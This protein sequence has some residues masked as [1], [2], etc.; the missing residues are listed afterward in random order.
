MRA[1]HT[2]ALVLAVGLCVAPAASA[3]CPA[4]T[5]APP[6]SAAAARAL[7]IGITVHDASDLGIS[8]FSGLKP[9]SGARLM[10]HAYLSY[11]ASNEQ[12]VLDEVRAYAAAGDAVLLTIRAQLANDA[13]TPRSY[14]AFVTE[15]LA[16][17]GRQLTAV[18]ITNEPNL[19]APPS[20]SDGMTPDVVEDLVTGVVTAQRYIRAHELAIKVGFN[21]VF[22]SHAP[23][24][25]RFWSELK[26]AATPEFLGDVDFLGL[27]TYPNLLSLPTPV[28][29]SIN[30]AELD[31]LQTARCY[32][33]YLGLAGSVPIEITEVGYPV[34]NASYYAAQADYWAR[35]LDVIH[36]YRAS[37]NID[38]VY[39]FMFRTVASASTALDF[40]IV[41]ADGSP[42]PAYHLIRARIATYDPAAPPTARVAPGRHRHRRHRRRR[43]RGHANK[44]HHR[45]SR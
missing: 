20:T 25:D 32:M 40:G 39:V 34:P 38:A 3:R 11:E 5:P 43:L 4:T 10:V 27:H 45:R 36:A 31:G 12:Q 9:P 19:P 30:Q 7:P 8:A 41:N 23:T 24:D 15:A 42:R 33:S 28:N 1:L 22:A 35:V 26:A 14:D 37:E 29:D 16:A 44:T 21:Y 2:F 6:V 17:V 13:P 18:E